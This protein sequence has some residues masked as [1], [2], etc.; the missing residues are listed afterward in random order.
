MPENYLLTSMVIFSR[1]MKTVDASKLK[2]VLMY[3]VKLIMT[4]GFWSRMMKRLKWSLPVR[5]I[6][7]A[8]NHR[9]TRK[10]SMAVLKEAA[11]FISLIREGNWHLARY[12]PVRV[13]RMRT[14]VILIKEP[15][16]LLILGKMET[17][18]RSNPK[19]V[20]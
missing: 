6:S 14:V 12:L 16:K 20:R 7:K 9:G 1:T 15:I 5:G 3:L 11:R 2:A 4:R 17:W 19:E 18:L 13:V 8:L 10:M